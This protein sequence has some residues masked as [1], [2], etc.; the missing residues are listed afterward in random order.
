MAQQK[1]LL[2]FLT[3]QYITNFDRNY[4][5]ATDVGRSKLPPELPSLGFAS[6]A[7]V[8]SRVRKPDLAIDSSVSASN[9][10]ALK[11]VAESQALNFD[12]PEVRQD[13]ETI[14]NSQNP[15]LKAELARVMKRVSGPTISLDQNTS[16]APPKT[17]G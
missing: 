5:P 9:A 15:Y 11:T 3:Q 13:L 17:Q 12:A 16:I 7:E 8:D 2:D 10:Q 4:N 14:F 6:R 1:Q